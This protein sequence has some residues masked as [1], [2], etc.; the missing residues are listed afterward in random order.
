[1]EGKIHL[2]KK[3]A[4]GAARIWIL[5]RSPPPW[6]CQ[7]FSEGG[8]SVRNYCD[9]LVLF[10]LE[11]T[12]D[13]TNTEVFRFFSTLP[14]VLNDQDYFLHNFFVKMLLMVV[15]SSTRRPRKNGRLHCIISKVYYH[16][17]YSKNITISYSII[18]IYR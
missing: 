1:M 15:I 7:K 18:L 10:I 9:V 6:K 16:F 4:A 2:F 3:P 12:V 17:T 5:Y 11:S 8:G 13:L 14:S